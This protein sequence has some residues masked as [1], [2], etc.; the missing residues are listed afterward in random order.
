MIMISVK[1][2]S[3]AIFGFF[4][5][6]VGMV[7]LERSFDFFKRFRSSRTFIDLICYLG[8]QVVSVCLFLIGVTSGL[9]IF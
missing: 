3:V 9:W 1:I 8:L 6:Y 7:C 5:G 4:C 2:L